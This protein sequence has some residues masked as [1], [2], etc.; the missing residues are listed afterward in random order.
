MEGTERHSTTLVV[1]RDARQAL[2]G[3]ALLDR[4]GGEAVVELPD[5]GSIL[6]RLLEPVDAPALRRFHDS[7][8]DQSRY[9]RFL[10]P[11]PH[12]SEAD[13]DHLTE[14]QHPDRVAF[15]A[16]ADGELAGVGRYERQGDT[17]EVAFTVADAHQGRGIGTILLAAL[18][19]CAAAH[20]IRS[21]FAEVLCENHAMLHVFRDAGYD[22][23]STASAGVVQVRFDLQP[24][25]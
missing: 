25:R 11:H 13:L 21:F 10:S 14:L 23:R 8:S 17:A 2:P 16:E 4:H 9:R 7:L 3:E 24:D 20:G 6:V 1:D 5:G 19:A 12:L 15:V 22:V 18:A